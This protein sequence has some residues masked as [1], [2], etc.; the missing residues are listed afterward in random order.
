MSITAKFIT[1]MYV[2]DLYSLAR[3]IP[4]LCLKLAAFWQHKLLYNL[5]KII[6]NKIH[7]SLCQTIC[8]NVNTGM[9]LYGKTYQI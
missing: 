7:F 9:I 1:A 5:N 6:F 8:G 4:L 2:I 3:N